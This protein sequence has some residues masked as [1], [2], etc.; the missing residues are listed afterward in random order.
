[1]CWLQAA[2]PPRALGTCWCGPGRR[3]AVERERDKFA[4]H[5]KACVIFVSELGA[6]VFAFSLMEGTC[7][8]ATGRL[9]ACWAHWAAGGR[10]VP[11]STRQ[12]GAGGARRSHGVRGCAVVGH[13]AGPEVPCEPGSWR[14]SGPCVSVFW[15]PPSPC[16]DCPVLCRPPEW[17]LTDGAGDTQTCATE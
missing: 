17:P 9:A 11:R 13:G 12:R 4:C 6:G 16:P 3:Q 2:L 14:V 5:W 15:G 10:L 8:T 7:S 1:M